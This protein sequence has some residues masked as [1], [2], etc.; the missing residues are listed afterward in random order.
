M[1]NGNNS[2]EPVNDIFK[3]NPPLNLFRSAL[4]QKTV[5]P[6]KALEFKKW[7]NGKKCSPEAKAEGEKLLQT[8]ESD[9]TGSNTGAGLAQAPNRTSHQG[10]HGG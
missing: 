6:A 4:A 2:K 7:L 5:T 1:S 3:Q 9:P 8:Y 10:G